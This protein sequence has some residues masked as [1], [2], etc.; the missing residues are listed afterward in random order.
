MFFEQ[1]NE[2]FQVS[3]SFLV[4]CSCFLT[5]WKPTAG[6]AFLL[7]FYLG[8]T[9]FVPFHWSATGLHHTAEVI[10]LEVFHLP[11]HHKDVICSVGHWENYICGQ[12]HMDGLHLYV[13]TGLRLQPFAIL[14][15]SDWDN[16][17]CWVEVWSGFDGSSIQFL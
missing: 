16:L 13:D 4:C 15:S 11:W 12:E 2:R 9:G 3:R 6:K 10:K 5:L 1:E 7:L 8:F 17:V 14:P